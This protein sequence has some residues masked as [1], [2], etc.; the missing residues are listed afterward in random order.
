MKRGSRKLL[1][2]LLLIFT[3]TAILY[4]MVKKSTEGFEDNSLT[5]FLNA[6]GMNPTEGYSKQVP[7]QVEELGKYVF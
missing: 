6:R 2:I 4:L 5:Q 1:I 7:K 3:I